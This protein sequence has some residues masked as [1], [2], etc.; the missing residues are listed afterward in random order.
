MLAQQNTC[1]VSHIYHNFEQ[2]TFENYAL[3]NSYTKSYIDTGETNKCLSWL[4][5][6][7]WKF[8]LWN[9]LIRKKIT[10]FCLIKKCIFE[11]GVRN[12]KIHSITFIFVK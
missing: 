1:T 2:T 6:S 9:I 11:W 7:V 10:Q 12:E 3:N 4:E 5:F 8:V